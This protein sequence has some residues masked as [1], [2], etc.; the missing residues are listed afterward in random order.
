M[1]NNVRDVNNWPVAPYTTVTFSMGAASASTQPHIYQWITIAGKAGSP[2]SADGTNIGARFI[3]PVGVAVGGHGNLYVGDSSNNTIRKAVPLPVF[4]S[5]THT[6]GRI[7]LTCS[8][9][10][11][12]TFQLQYNSD[13]ASTT[14]T[15]LGNPVTATSGTMSATD[16]PGPDQQR[17]YRVIVQP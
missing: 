13:L 12:Q 3:G 6:N 15:N 5:V 9:A 16:T 17:I 4:Q 7:E 11:G 2:G 10:P 14:W 8:A 1:V